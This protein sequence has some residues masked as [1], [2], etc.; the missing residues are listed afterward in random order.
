MK[1]RILLIMLL[2]VAVHLPSFAALPDEWLAEGVSEQLA[3]WRKKTCKDVTYDLFF[4]IPEEKSEPVP[5]EMKLAFTMDAPQPIVLDFKESA[6]HI[7]SVKLNGRDVDYRFEKEHIL[8]PEHGARA[9]K[10]T[11]EITFVA[12]NQSLN[13]NDEYLYTL[14]VPDR[15]RT[16][17]PCFDQ[18]G[19]K[20]RFSLSLEVPAEW[21]TVSNT[22]V[23]HTESRGG[24]TFVRFG[25]TEPLSTY[26]FAFVAGK[27]SLQTYDDGKHRF[28][29]YYRETDP[30][31][32]KQ[33]DD[34]FREVAASL[35][36]L[37]AYTGIPYPF[38]KYDFIILPGFQFG[39]MEHTGATFY[40][41]SRIF[42][43]KY[44]T[45]DEKLS[46]S[47]LIAHETAHMWFGDL[48]TMEWF[49]DVWTK[50]V[51]ANHYAACICEPLFPDI[52][53][54][55]NRMK[56]FYNASLSE[57]RTPGSN[58]I[59][60]PLAN[61]NSAG[62]VY[63]NIIYNKAPVM[64]EKMVELMG[65]KEFR[66]GIRIYLKRFSYGNATWDDLIQILDS[67]SP[68]DLAQFSDAWVNRRGV[69]HISA[70]ADGGMLTVTQTDPFKSGT[71]WPQ[72]FRITLVGDAG[73]QRNVE[74]KM[75]GAA[76]SIPLDFRPLYIL[77]NTDGKGYGCFLLDKATA[78][79]LLANWQTIGDETARYASLMNL[80]ENYLLGR[81]TA[82]DWNRSITDGLLSEKNE[83]IATALAANVAEVMREL[84]AEDAAAAEKKYWEMSHAHALPSCRLQLLRSLIPAMRSTAMT[85][86]LYGVWERQTEPLLSENDYTTLSYELA[87]RMP[88]QYSRILEIQR[89]RIENPDRLRQ[90]D[91]ISRAVNPDTGALDSL[92]AS[93]KDKDNRRIE[94]WTATVLGYLNHPLREAHAVKYIYP[95]LDLLQEVQR[96]G[97]IF[98]PSNWAKVLLRGHHSKEAYDEV[99]RF[100]NNH[101]DYPQLLKNK[102]LQAAY[103][104][105]RLHRPVAEAL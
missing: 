26:L 77:P 96:T 18:P 63:G 54:R 91:F 60:Q 47:E 5:A 11:V 44:A 74:V 40:N 85:D 33:L 104:L 12:G 28:S 98:F 57:D 83:L 25:Q 79:W 78:A 68:V 59:R 39:G 56:N 67:I 36:W 69:S 65:E 71:L 101:P 21:K 82:S 62:L 38:A 29:A 37:E 23:N 2:C 27:F 61:M 16:L 3:S 55:L 64:M 17:F 48:V 86:T 15:A 43:N 49:N 24:R 52:N 89:K 102:V 72:T 66:E 87:L 34:V 20:A 84:P 4:S 19:I 105:F 50:E 41:D 45:L 90:F 92:F 6:G 100:L 13:R 32:V 10:N 75:T 70:K 58:P 88:G 81:I 95:G 42:L 30:D 8:I 80:R 94:P 9:G 73:Q 14:L 103:S 1:Q 22:Y 7:Q 99:E 76:V 31:K 93:L 51:F 97:D 35:E 46:R 53:H